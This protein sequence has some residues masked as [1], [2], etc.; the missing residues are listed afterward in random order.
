MILVPGIVPQEDRRRI[1]LCDED[2]HRAIIV[3]IA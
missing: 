1:V 2:I 3:E